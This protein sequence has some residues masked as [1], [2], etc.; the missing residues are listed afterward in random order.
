M[1]N[2]QVAKVLWILAQ[3]FFLPMI[4]WFDD[5]RSAGDYWQAGGIF[6]L[7]EV[8]YVLDAILFLRLFRRD[9]K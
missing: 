3:G 8:L 1:K 7:L 6:L 4:L 5:L 9:K 2:P